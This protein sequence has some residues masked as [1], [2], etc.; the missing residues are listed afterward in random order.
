VGTVSGQTQDIKGVIVGR[1]GPNV[2][3]KPEGVG[4][5]VTVTLDDSTKVQAIKGKLG[6]RKSEMAFT[7]LIPGL[8][9]NVEAEGKEGQLVAKTVKFK[10]SALHS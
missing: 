4:G 8:P 5:N 9:V 7:A 10:A 3:I 2:I 6:I 1:D